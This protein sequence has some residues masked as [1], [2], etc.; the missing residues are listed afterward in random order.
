MR[1]VRKYENARKE[2]REPR[3]ATARDPEYSRG[4][5]R[6]TGNFSGIFNPGF[7]ARENARRVRKTRDLSEPETRGA[8]ISEQIE[9]KSR[10]V[11][12]EAEDVLPRTYTRNTN[13]ESPKT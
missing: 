4:M 7:S 8:L 1:D 10:I 6:R 5:H 2:A 13:R 11:D 3:N 9:S 12:R